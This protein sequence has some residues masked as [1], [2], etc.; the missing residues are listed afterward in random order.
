MHSPKLHFI[1][2]LAN[3]S[4]ATKV[5]YSLLISTDSIFSALIINA[6]YFSVNVRSVK[7]RADKVILF[8]FMYVFIRFYTFEF[9]C[10]HDYQYNYS[11]IASRLI[12]ALIIL[13]I[14]ISER[15]IPNK[16]LKKLKRAND[17]TEDLKNW[18]YS[19]NTI[20]S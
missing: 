9:L 10:T 12:Y 11:T 15:L 3:D 5:W 20:K 18:R 17:E 1:L 4:I 16:W 6:E 13:S 8:R 7:I 14:I 2:L 19:K